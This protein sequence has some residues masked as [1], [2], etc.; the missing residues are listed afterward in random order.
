MRLTLSVAFD[1]RLFS[2]WWEVPGTQG[3][4][5]LFI[6][7][8][9]VNSAGKLTAHAV[10]ELKVL[11]SFSGGGSRVSKNVNASAVKKGVAQARGYRKD[12]TA[13]NAMLC[14]YDMRTPAQADGDKCFD[15]VR[16]IAIKHAVHLKSYRLYGSPDD[17][18]DDQ[19][20]S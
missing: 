20:A 8:R 16:V 11:R 9:D 14:C 6:T 13:L 17:L 4:C 7:S 3:R 10:L 12:K 19:M 5:D 18:R 1:M 15:P 2:V